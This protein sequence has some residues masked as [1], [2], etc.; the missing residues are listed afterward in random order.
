VIVEVGGYIIVVAPVTLKMT[1][2]VVV[3]ATAGLGAVM[4]MAMRVPMISR[5]YNACACQPD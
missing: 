4:A 1:G 5:L 3:V 2:M